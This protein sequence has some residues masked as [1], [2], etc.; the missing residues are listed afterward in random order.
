MAR[1]I[2]SASDV[3]LVDLPFAAP[4]GT[5]HDDGIFRLQDPPVFGARPHFH[6]GTSRLTIHKGYMPFA[7]F[8]EKILTPLP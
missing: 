1:F 7:R 8:E 5:H 3:P 4:H 2:P 6:D